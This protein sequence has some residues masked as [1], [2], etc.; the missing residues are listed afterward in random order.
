MSLL[1]P[2]S[3]K[4]RKE[5]VKPIKGKSARWTTVVFGDYGLKA[6]TSSYVTN[7]ELEAARKVIT[8]YIKKVGK[9]WLRVYPRVPIT[10]KGLEM[11]MGSGKG[12]VDVYTARVPR[13][14]IIFELSWLNDEEARTV[15]IKA[16]KKLSVKARVLKKWEIR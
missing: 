5:H 10:K 9:M 12:D 6:I 3:W 8:R 13:G 2:K 15:L 7:R 4:H 11:P 1:S 16:S 14:K